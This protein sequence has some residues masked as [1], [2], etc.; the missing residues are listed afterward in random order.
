MKSVALFGGSFDPPHI[1]H[2]RVVEALEKL[3]FIDT[4]IVMPTFL[5]PFKSSS[6]APAELRAQWLQKIFAPYKSVHVSLFEA[7]MQRKVATIETVRMLAQK[8]DKIYVVIGAD[9]LHS[10]PQWQEYEALQEM[11]TFLVATRDNTQIPK[12]YITLH[13]DENISSSELREHMQLSK[14]PKQCATTIQQYYKEHNA[15][16]N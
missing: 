10:L 13:V 8:Y 14:L 4:I 6:T 9:N 1:G 11:V 12:E 5:N 16:T 7:T 3:S 2:I 15:K